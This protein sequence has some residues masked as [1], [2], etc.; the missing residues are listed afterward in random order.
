MVCFEDWR[1][2]TAIVQFYNPERCVQVRT[3]CDVI[4]DRMANRS[5]DLYNVVHG[6]IDAFCSH[7]LSDYTL[8]C[9]GVTDHTLSVSNDWC[10]G[11]TTQCSHQGGDQSLRYFRVKFTLPPVSTLLLMS[12]LID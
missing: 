5:H 7:R 9:K 6:E 11:H 2:L 12:F 8:V 10:D 3:V 4:G 1:K